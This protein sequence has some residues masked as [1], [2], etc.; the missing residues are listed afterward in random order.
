MFTAKEQEN[1]EVGSSLLPLRAIASRAILV[2]G[3][4]AEQHRRVGFWKAVGSTPGLVAALVWA[5][6]LAVAIA[7]AAIGLVV[8]RRA[9]PLLTNPGAGLLATAGAPQLSVTT[10]GPVLARAVVVATLATPVPA[11]EAART[12][13]VAARSVKGPHTQCR[14]VGTATSELRGSHHCGSM[15]REPTLAVT[16]PEVR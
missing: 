12:S 11:L 13:T 15:A 3:R 9:A 4:M 1:L 14:E 10:V 2:G 5:E 16:S 8:G 7:A 6:Y